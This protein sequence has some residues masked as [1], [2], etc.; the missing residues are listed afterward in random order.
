MSRVADPGALVV[1]EAHRMGVKVVP[2]V[3]PSSLLLAL[4]ASGLEG[5]RFLF[6]WVYHH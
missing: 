2:L 4:M 3:G 5:Q 1:A 6:S